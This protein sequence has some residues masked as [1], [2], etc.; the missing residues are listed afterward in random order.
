MTEETGKG[1][2]LIVDDEKSMC[3]LLS[4][5]LEKEGYRVDSATNGEGALKLLEKGSYDLV[6]EDLKMPGMDGIELLRKIKEKDSL[7]VVMVMTAYSSWDTAVEAMRLGAHDYIRK[8]FDNV[9]VKEMV[10]RA[11]EQ[12]RVL[13]KRTE[14]GES[15]IE[16]MIGHSAAMREVFRLVRLVAPTDTTILLQGESGVGKNMLARIIHLASLRAHHPFISVNC[17]GFSEALLESELFGHVQGAFTGAIADKK[18]LFEIADKGS[19]FLDQITEM[20]PAT[21][22][23]VL[24]MLEDREFR[25]LGSTETKRVDVRFIAATNC[26][27]EREVENNAFRE[28]LY[29][30]LNVVSIPLP[31]LRERHE[32]IPLLAGRFLAMYARSMGKAVTSISREAMEELLDFE[33]PGNVRE[34][35][36]TIQRAVAL[37]EGSEIGLEHLAGKMKSLGVPS[38][39]EPIIPAEG[40]DLEGVLGEIEKEYLRRALEATSSNASR[41]ASLLGISERSMRYK[42]RKHDI[43]PSKK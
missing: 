20:S 30:R 11:V 35:Q 16:T 41:A 42:L 26:D 43:R 8:P 21:Q 13:R 32:D 15:P 12:S 2:V 28:D 10:S 40:I 25:A 18:G 22:V 31:A 24:R 33:W 39:L 9:A 14:T 29:Y 27:I 1:R 17:G 19:F 36:N 5:M 3:E 23:K 34:L 38:H 6:L 4:V 7:A 37:A